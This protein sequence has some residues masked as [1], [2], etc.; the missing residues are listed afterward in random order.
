MQHSNHKIHSCT[1]HFIMMA[2]LCCSIPHATLRCD[3]ESMSVL[4]WMSLA[5][6]VR[7]WQV[8]LYLALF[9]LVTTISRVYYSISHLY[10]SIR[11]M[12]VPH[13]LPIEIRVLPFGSSAITLSIDD[14]LIVQ[15]HKI[16]RECPCELFFFNH[17]NRKEYLIKFSKTNQLPNP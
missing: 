5:F 6:F 2:I 12:C 14:G 8:Q 11:W 1:K 4:R 10:Y 13:N 16:L 15:A 7:V 9:F 3:K 17:G